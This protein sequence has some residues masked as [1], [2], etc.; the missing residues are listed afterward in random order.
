MAGPRSESRRLTEMV[1]VRFRRD[2]LRELQELADEVG[3][4]V[5]ELLREGGL[6][7][8]RTGRVDAVRAAS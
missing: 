1:A 3:I 8:V 2:D 5:P 6:A 4:S 7:M